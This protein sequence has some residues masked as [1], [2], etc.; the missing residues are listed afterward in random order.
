MYPIDVNHLV[1]KGTLGSRAGDPT[2]DDRASRLGRLR[3]AL[4]RTQSAEPQA[5]AAR[6][7]C[8]R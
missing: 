3:R 6:P 4:T 2:L 7:V 1:R 5:R 8:V